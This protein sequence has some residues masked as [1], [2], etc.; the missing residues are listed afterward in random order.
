MTAFFFRTK[1]LHKE[2]KMRTCYVGHRRKIDFIKE[3]GM[4][5]DDDKKNLSPWSKAGLETYF[6]EV[7]DEPIRL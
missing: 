7:K 4:L 5:I 2:D 1:E 6:V 3:D